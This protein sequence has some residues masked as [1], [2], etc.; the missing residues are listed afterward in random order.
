WWKSDAANELPA[1]L[2]VGDIWANRRGVDLQEK[3]CA[4]GYFC[5][6]AGDCAVAP[7]GVFHA[8][9]RRPELSAA[10][11]AGNHDDHCRV[12]QRSNSLG[13]LELDS[14]GNLHVDWRDQR[15]SGADPG[16]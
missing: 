9:S 16:L 1:A 5:G 4:A 2:T 6:A 10:V 11:C 12:G 3:Y 15:I 8:I 14:M 7:A 13:A